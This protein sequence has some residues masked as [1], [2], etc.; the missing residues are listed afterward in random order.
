MS[1]ENDRQQNYPLTLAAIQQS[2]FS[3]DS[4][5][6]VLTH[7]EETGVALLAS[8]YEKVLTKVGKL[9]EVVAKELHLLRCGTG[10]RSVNVDRELKCCDEA[11]SRGEPWARDIGVHLV[12][13][14][15]TAYRLRSRRGSHDSFDPIRGDATTAAACAT[16]CVWELARLSA[17]DHVW[18]D[19]FKELQW[20]THGVYPLVEIMNGRLVVLATDESATVQIRQAL[21]VSDRAV[22]LGILD[23]AI[24][25]KTRNALSQALL[26]M[27]RGAEVIV[28]DDGYR[29]TAKGTAMGRADIRR[30]APATTI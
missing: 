10:T 22:A 24:P 16:W 11:R 20:A 29:L 19:L 30:I 12:D 5:R 1:S 25:S 3:I 4:T 18:D 9:V 13:F 27:R 23:E 15:R 14:C 26:R 28:D 21:M 6:R 2:W 17:P 8:D 7:H